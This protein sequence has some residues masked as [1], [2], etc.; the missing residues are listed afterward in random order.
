MNRLGLRSWRAATITAITAAIVVIAADAWYVEGM[1]DVERERVR[2]RMLPYANALRSSIDRRA[3]VLLGFHAFVSSRPS[4]AALEQEFALYA[5]G[6]VASTPGV[7]ALQYIDDGRIV[8]IEPL[9]PN[10]AAL[11]MD[12]ARN[13]REEVR[14]EH[15]RAMARATPSVTGP[16][17]LAEGGTGIL[18]QYRLPVRPGFPQLVAVVLDAPRVVQDAG[19]PDAGSG[20]LLDV[21]SRGGQRMAGDSIDA[22]DA[23]ELVPLVFE[24]ET[25]TL[26]AL[27]AD[28][29]RGA[30]RDWHVA[31]RLTMALLW[32]LAVLIAYTIGDRLDRLARE[33]ERSGSAL[34]VAMRAGGT[35]TWSVDFESGHAEASVATAAM[36]GIGEARRGDLV[37]QA[38]DLMPPE[39]RGR[40]MRLCEQARAGDRPGFATEFRVVRPD[41]GAVHLHVCLGEMVR[42]TAGRPH[43]LVGI[44]SDVTERRAMEEHLR[45]S[46]RLEAVGKL[47]GGVAHDFNNLLSAIRGF[48][49]LSVGHLQQVEGGAAKEIVEDLEQ[50]LESTREGARLTTQLLAFSRRGAADVSRVDVVA[51]INDL[52]P[53]LGR[54]FAGRLE[55]LFTPP[56]SLPAA[57]AEAG[58]LTQVLLTILVRARDAEPGP[59]GVQLRAFHVPATSGRRPL[60]APVG[61]WVALEIVEQGHR[62]G[63]ARKPP[64]RPTPS[65][66]LEL[67][68]A[69]GALGLAVLASGLEASGGRLV[70]EGTTGAGGSARVYLPP[71]NNQP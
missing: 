56:E 39:D 42:D 48:A 12:L 68:G 23:P 67:G 65:A 57:R 22:R 45:Q 51:A 20:L 1:R 46:E 15:Q 44:L 9:E 61:E 5:R 70:L 58:L 37:A 64:R 7:R 19:I 43:S 10:R 31:F 41:D 47:A 16:F 38:L 21:T 62:G 40:V 14:A 54:L 11:G 71:W 34:E 8:R 59:T 50:V 52:K 25:W 30:V 26:R 66:G 4:R 27:P 13:P 18:L 28:G 69:D 29:W 55:V 17:P 2:D 35:G 32:L 53:I 3:G 36:F 49:E 60:D 33:K 63:A 24:G 6:A